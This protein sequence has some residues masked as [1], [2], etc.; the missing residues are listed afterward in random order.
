MLIKKIQT[1]AC[2]R[3]PISVA[4]HLNEEHRFDDFTTTNCD[5]TLDASRQ[6]ISGKE[7]SALCKIANSSGF[8]D[9]FK[10]M[11][12]GNVI[13]TTENRAVLHTLLR[14][15][16]SHDHRTAEVAASLDKMRAMASQIKHGEWVGATGKKITD[17]VNI[18]IGGSDLGPRMIYR[19][20]INEH[21][22]IPIHWV[23]NIDPA[24]IAQKLKTL[25]AETTLF[26]VSSKSFSTPETLNNAL[27]ARRWLNEQG[28][29]DVSKHVIAASSNIKAATAFGI[30]AENIFP[31]WDW[32][33]GR[34]S[35]WSAIG[36]PIMIG[37]HEGTFEALLEGAFE[38]DVL[39]EQEPIE[40]NVSAQLAILELWNQQAN[41]T[42]SRAVLPYCH[43]LR[44]LP[45]HLQQLEMESLGKSTN[46]DGQRVD[47]ST[48][49]VVWG[50]EG[51]NGQHSYHQLLHQG[52]QHIAAEIILPLNTH[53]DTKQHAKLVA[54]ALAQSQAFCF[55]QSQAEAK[56]ALLSRGMDEAQ[57][58]FI[59]RHKEIK[60]NKPHSIITMNELNPYTLGAL[61]AAYENKVF[62]CGFWLNINAFDQWGVELGK[63]HASAIEEAI[64]SGDLSSLDEG[65]QRIIHDYTK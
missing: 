58:D 22:H 37:T 14:N 5:I 40:N 2:H 29:E 42:H 41:K 52:N 3:A 53:A 7:F 36:L 47:Y 13:N 10:R 50:T 18:G 64:E 19:A 54:N 62:F 49:G 35:L 24:N 43:D 65:Y 26:V 12:D 6:N 39:A 46:L 30:N 32:V 60:G 28:I 51:S 57:A 27:A 56:Q 17:V 1:L 16:K 59:A 9:A 8:N 63:V 44:L 21:N 15:K 34:F 45:A 25:S 11:R 33:G 55:G 20:L 23:A 4:E 31:L 38:M 61:I 48:G